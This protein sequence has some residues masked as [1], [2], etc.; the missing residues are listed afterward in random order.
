MRIYYLKYAIDFAALCAV[1]FIFFFRRWKSGGKKNLIVRTVMYVYVSLVLF[2]TLMPVIASLPYMFNHPYKLMYLELFGD[3]L[4]DRGDTVRQI[5]LNVL[6][7]APFGFL[8]PLIKPRK[9]WT[10]AFW[11]FVFSLSIE[12][13]QPLMAGNRASDVTDLVTNTIGGVLGYCI[14]LIMRRPL[15]ITG[16]KIKG[17]GTCRNKSHKQHDES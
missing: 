6:M 17:A 15:K 2:V 3:Y 12:L 16:E 14:Y 4:A 1:Y 7:M 5:V 10:C 8:L 11:T 13:M 9:L